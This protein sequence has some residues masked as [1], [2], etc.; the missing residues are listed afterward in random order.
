MSFASRALRMAVCVSRSTWTPGPDTERTA[1]AMPALSIVSRRMSPKS[2]SR[3]SKRVRTSGG[4]S[5]T[6]L[7]Q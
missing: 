6:V 2:E 7:F 3:A 4:T 1:R 5:S